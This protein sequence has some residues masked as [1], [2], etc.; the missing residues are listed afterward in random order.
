M[1]DLPSVLLGL[2]LIRR[3]GRG[4]ASGD[5]VQVVLEQADFD[6]AAADADRLSVGVIL[7]RIAHSDH[8]YPVDRNLMIQN[9][10][11]NNSIGHLLRVADGGL[12]VTGR[13]ALHF[14]NV[15]ALIFQRG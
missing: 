6:A 9:E 11:A 1:S 13:E 14:N 12:S 15:A 7:R 2:W 3:C 8:E 5:L 10:I 4:C